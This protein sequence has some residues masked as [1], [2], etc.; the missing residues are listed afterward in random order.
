MFVVVWGMCVFCEKPFAQNIIP[1]KKHGKNAKIELL[2]LA[3]QKKRKS[4]QLRTKLSGVAVEN[5]PKKVEVKKR[6]FGKRE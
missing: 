5:I 4:V 3:K 2:N 6:K 1:V